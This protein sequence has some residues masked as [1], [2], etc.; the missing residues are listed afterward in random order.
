MARRNR[1]LSFAGPNDHA[2][3]I[4]R[5]FKQDVDGTGF[6]RLKRTIARNLTLAEAQA[7][8]HDPETSSSTCTS[9][10]GRARTRK[11]GEWFDGYDLMP[12]WTDKPVN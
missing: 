7:W 11:H 12:G 4:V 2:Y 8:C 10:A 6:S 5:M 1:G 9:A 3:K